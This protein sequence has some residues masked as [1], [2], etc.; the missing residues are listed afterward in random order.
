MEQKPFIG[1][2]VRK[3]GL[4]MRIEI[5][6]LG[7]DEPKLTSGCLE[8]PEVHFDSSLN[9]D[10]LSVLHSR[11]ELPLLNRLN[12]F[13]IQAEAERANHFQFPG[14]ALFVDDDEENNSSLEF[15]LAR[16]L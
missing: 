10:W 11:T 7:T 1:S 6:G 12:R 9:G 13:L 14:V 16:F 15:R 4:S 3:Q 8:Q 2:S 5:L